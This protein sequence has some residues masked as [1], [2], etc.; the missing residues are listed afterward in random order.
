MDSYSKYDAILGGI[1]L[2]VTLM[3]AGFFIAPIV[4]FVA[5]L[6][7][8]AL[9]GYAMF[10]IPPTRPTIE[11]EEPTPQASEVMTAD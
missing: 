5:G 1:G 11:T 9:A 7:G 3:L 8:V 6:G 2:T 10:V 4:T